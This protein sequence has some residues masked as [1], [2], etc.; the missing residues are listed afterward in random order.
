MT[1]QA[2]ATIRIWAA[3]TG[4]IVTL[5][6][7]LPAEAVCSRRPTVTITTS[8]AIGNYNPWAGTAP[9]VTA[10][11][12]ILNRGAATCSFSLTFLATTL[13]PFMTSGA[14]NL[15]YTVKSTGGNSLVYTTGTP[16]T[17]QRLDINNVG[18]GATV[19]V[20]VVVSAPLLQVVATGS[21]AD[22]TISLQVYDNTGGLQPN[23]RTVLF[24][25]TATVIG[26]CNLPVPGLTSMNFNSAITNGLPNAGSTQSTSIV[27][28]Q[29]TA[30]T[31]VQ[32]SGNSLQTVPLGTARP[33]FDNFINWTATATFG[34][35][36]ATITTTGLATTPSVLSTAKNTA[37]AGATS[38]T[39]SIS[40]VHLAV[41]NHI[42]A[43]V[44]V[45]ILTIQID[46]SL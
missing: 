42:I 7:S 4:T 43:G 28:A 19:V 6:G 9:S 39:I 24:P 13:S 15:T 26:V 8:A 21:Y 32:L 33:G 5:L 22:N 11:V 12:S 40:N 18:S 23:P 27:N 30:P 31:R 20:N 3:I 45:S 46:P 17:A 41:G 1:R 44:Y 25:V 38:G 37:A 14:S 34:S 2:L 36:T 16:T 29:C 35:A 10:V